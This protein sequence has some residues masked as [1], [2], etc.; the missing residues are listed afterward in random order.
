MSPTDEKLE[1]LM[2]ELIA[3]GR[4]IYDSWLDKDAAVRAARAALREYVEQTREEAEKRG[5]DEG[6]SE[7]YEAGQPD[8]DTQFRQYQISAIN[9]EV[10]SRIDGAHPDALENLQSDR[11][12]SMKEPE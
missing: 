9:R 6:W 2:D 4:S 1:K 3:A 10:Q 8:D 11:R 12:A 7:G 5:H